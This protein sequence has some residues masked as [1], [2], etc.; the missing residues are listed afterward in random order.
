MN[1]TLW[2]F[3][4][5]SDK[6]DILAMMT[7]V[8]AASLGTDGRGFA[9]VA[10]ETRKMTQKMQIMIEKALFD[11]EEINYEKM[12]DIA[13]QL[14]LLVL[15]IAIEGKNLGEKGLQAG[16]FAEEIRAL[17]ATLCTLRNEIF[18]KPPEN[19]RQ[20]TKKSPM[21]AIPFPKSPLSTLNQGCSFLSLTIAGVS[22]IENLGNIKEVNYCH[23][24]HMG[25]TIN[26]RGNELPLVNGFK[27]LGKPFIEKPYYVIIRTPWAEKDKTYAVAVDS[28]DNMFYSP[29][30]TPVEPPSDM[31][32]AKYVRECWENENGEPFYFMDWAKMV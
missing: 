4:K 27:I 14:N 8:Q 23:L 13:L 11:D 25:N 20:Q 26:L 12:D 30:G 10:E 18:A 3:Q 22:V 1:K 2:K 17:T 7:T 16:I 6:L 5:I 28:C 29:I 9:V 24:E 19:K 32:L 21:Y 31:P 15:N